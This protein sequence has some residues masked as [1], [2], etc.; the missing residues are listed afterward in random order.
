MPNR[1]E[2]KSHGARW[3]FGVVVL[4]AIIFRPFVFSTASAGPTTQATLLGPLPTTQAIENMAISENCHALAMSVLDAGG[5]RHVLTL[6]GK[7][8][9]TGDLFPQIALCPDGKRLA[10]Y[11]RDGNRSFVT[12]DGLRD[13]RFDR[14]AD[15]GTSALLFSPDSKHIAFVAGTS[16]GWS[17]VLDGK[18]G[19]AF[20][21]QPSRLAFS[22]DSQHLAFVDSTGGSQA[23]VL[24]GKGG[25]AYAEI[26]ELCFGR[27]GGHVAY[28]ARVDPGHWVAVVDD[29]A[30]PPGSAYL[31]VTDLCLNTDGT[32]SAF[33]AREQDTP[34]QWRVIIDG[35]AGDP[36]T[37][38]AGGPIFS[39]A[40]NHV[41]YTA[42]N[43]TDPLGGLSNHRISAGESTLV[44]DSVSTK[45]LDMV[46]RVVYSPDGKRLALENEGAFST[47]NRPYQWS[48]SAIID[49]KVCNTLDALIG[50]TFSP[51]NRRLVYFGIHAG[52]AEEG[53]SIF[54]DTSYVR[55]RFHLSIMPPIFSDGSM[56]MAYAGSLAN[57]DWEMMLDDSVVVGYEPIRAQADRG[58]LGFVNPSLWSRDAPA[59]FHLSQVPY[60]FDPDDTLN[61]F[62]AKGGNIYWVQIKP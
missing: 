61:F 59:S 51:D 35:R 49:G 47:N 54:H 2:S 12:V 28:A 16:A 26:K 24:D 4:A 44:V 9:A 15:G 6:N 30:T 14:I 10:Y 21:T 43:I 29:K 19:A 32:R 41:A 23:V 45:F 52:R 56:H 20:A 3:A 53:W 60:H 1:D 25:Q 50:I 37:V 48:Y 40:G 38:I 27:T 46:R 33:R 7:T 22:P 57:G 55:G 62:G 18:P 5:K 17:V 42:Y 58:P 31:D 36:F 11:E 8:I 34:Q 39:D 13:S